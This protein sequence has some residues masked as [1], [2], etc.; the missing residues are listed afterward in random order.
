MLTIYTQMVCYN[1][2]YKLI[3]SCYCDARAHQ[4]WLPPKC[5][6]ALARDAGEQVKAARALG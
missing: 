5:D 4:L 2:P 3:K 6:C 1:N